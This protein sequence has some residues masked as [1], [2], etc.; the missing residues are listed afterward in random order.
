MPGAHRLLEI[1]AIAAFFVLD[2]GLC[3][4]VVNAANTPASWCLVALA[5]LVG[6]LVADFASGVAHWLFDRYFTVETP[7][8]GQNF[9]K[10]FREHHVDPKGITRHDFVETNGNNC[11]GTVPFL[12]AMH[13][14]PLPDDD[15]LWLLAQSGVAA[16]MLFVFCT[17]QFHAWAHADEVPPPIGLLQRLGLILRTRHH[18]IH[19]RAPFDRYY[20][21]TTGWLNPLLYR[22]QFF[23]RVEGLIWR[24][25]GVR[26]GAD[27]AAYAGIDP[28]QNP[29]RRM[30]NPLPRDVVDGARG[31]GKAGP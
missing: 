28:P 2:V 17:N 21:I 8:V 20:C 5:L 1:A 18:D 9:V 10:P 25:T 29:D 3:W 26:A 16:L 27:D 30:D 7:L 6:Y 31:V 19:H 23:P 15:P 4:R 12:A 13:L 14:L 11:I 24:L 22:V